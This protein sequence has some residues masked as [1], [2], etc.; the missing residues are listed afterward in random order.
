MGVPSIVSTTARYVETLEPGV[1]A[2]LASNQEE[3]RQALYALIDDP[4][5]RRG[6][7]ANARRKL[8]ANQPEACRGC[9]PCRSGEGPAWAATATAQ[10]QSA[11]T[12]SSA[13][14]FFPPQ[15][16]ADRRHPGQ[17][18]LLHTIDADDLEFAASPATMT[19]RFPR[20]RTED[21]AGVPCSES[22]R[23]R[24]RIW[25]GVRSTQISAKFMLIF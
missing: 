16:S 15:P 10:R 7:V 25:S 5:L 1:D 20:V 19:H 22:A 18:R 24:K 21:Y 2:L 13:N 14:I 4:E 8:E 3:W 12:D 17:F 11:E 6:L 9:R 23:R